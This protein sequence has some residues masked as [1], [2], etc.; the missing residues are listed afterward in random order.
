[1]D[2]DERL[3][4]LAGALIE[5]RTIDWSAARSAARDETTRRLIDQLWGIARIAEAHRELPLA[6]DDAS[7]GHRPTHGVLD[8][9]IGGFDGYQLVEP[10]GES[11]LAIAYRATTPGSDGAP[12]AIKLVKW[13]L[14]SRSLAARFDETQARLDRA[15]P[16]IVRWIRCGTSPEGRFYLVMEYAEGVPLTTFANRAELGLHARLRLWDSVCGG[17]EQGHEAGVLHRGLKPS[18]VLAT[19]GATGPAVRILDFGVASL[20]GEREAE[21]LLLSRYGLR[22]PS[23]GYIPPEE[24]ESRPHVVDERADVFALGSLLFELLNGDPPMKEESLAVH[25]AREARRI[26]REW[27][28]R[29]LRGGMVSDRAL[30]AALDRVIS[31]ARSKDPAARFESVRGLRSSIAALLA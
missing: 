17:V 31:R 5:G 7:A 12:V 13:E 15:G 27:T 11:P 30:S 19:K 22:I 23:L 2:R 9:A 26:V 28:S 1:M 25:D 8:G 16:S 6:G 20:L 21:W 18:N 14:D 10:L 4:E 29:P 24:A 3:R